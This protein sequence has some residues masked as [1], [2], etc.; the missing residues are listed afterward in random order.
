VF[1]LLC[2][3]VEFVLLVQ[4]TPGMAWST[5]LGGSSFILGLF[6]FA[7]ADNLVVCRDTL[8]CSVY[9]STIQDIAMN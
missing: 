2:L 3:L 8:F 9:P 6:R 4:I 1:K 5:G 7:L